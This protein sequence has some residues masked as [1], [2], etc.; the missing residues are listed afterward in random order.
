MLGNEKP[1]LTGFLEIERYG[2]YTK[3]IFLPI[4]PDIIGLQTHTLGK[5]LPEPRRLR[6]CAAEL[7]DGFAPR[8]GFRLLR[9]APGFFV[10][11][12]HAACA[13]YK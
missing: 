12:P 1:V 8:L 13:A 10:T 4:Q 2:R 7:A 5:P 11:I 3:N 6:Q 9:I